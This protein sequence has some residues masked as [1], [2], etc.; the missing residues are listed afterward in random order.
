MKGMEKQWQTLH[1]KK[2]IENFD[3]LIGETGD[4]GAGENGRLP[5]TVTS[6]R[7]ASAM[8]PSLAPHPFVGRRQ[9]SGTISEVQYPMR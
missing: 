9:L 3:M 6:Q 5:E 8:L 2:T 7:I 4:K 1:E